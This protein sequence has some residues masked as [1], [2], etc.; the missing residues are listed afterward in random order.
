VFAGSR[1][2][3]F[4][5]AMIACLPRLSGTGCAA[6]TTLEGM[7][8]DTA[9]L[10]SW[11]AKTTTFTIGSANKNQPSEAV[12]LFDLTALPKDMAL[13]SCALRLV[14]AKDDISPGKDNGLLLQLSDQAGAATPRA[15]VNLATQWKANSAVTLRSSS[16]CKTIEDALN[17]GHAALYLHTSSRALNVEFVAASDDLSSVPRLLLTYKLRRNLLV[18]AD[19]TQIRQ[20]AQHSAR[21]PG[22]LYDPGGKFSTGSFTTRSFDATT[23][24][25]YGDLKQAP[26]LHDGKIF[27]VLDGEN[28]N[29]RLIAIN[30][31]GAVLAE[32]N[33][34]PEK[35]VFLLA[36]R[37]RLYYVTENAFISYNIGPGPLLGEKTRKDF[38]SIVFGKKTL[39]TLRASPT[40][41]TDGSLYMVTNQAVH[42]FSPYPGLTELWRYTTNRNNIASVTL[43]SDEATAYVLFASEGDQ[44][45]RLDALATGTGECRWSQSFPTVTKGNDGMPV[46]VVAG[47]DVLVTSEYPAGKNLYVISDPELPPRPT[48]GN[49]APIAQQCPKT[50]N[51]LL[52]LSAQGEQIAAPMAGA[53]EKA[54]FVRGGQLCWL[55]E[56]SNETCR[57]LDFDPKR[58]CSPNDTKNIT[59]LVGDSTA[60]AGQATHFYGLVSAAESSATQV[61]AISMV[62]KDPPA[63]PADKDLS[64]QSTTIVGLGPNLTLGVDGTL[65]NNNNN[66]T[67]M[68]ILPTTSDNLQLSADLLKDPLE[69]IFRANEIRVQDNL[70][71]PND[72]NIVL[73]ASGRIL[74][75]RGFAVPAGAQLRAGTGFQPKPP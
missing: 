44:T 46:P 12:L 60:V 15:A 40:I 25:L 50:E 52:T 22:K 53:G 2:L 74:F 17:K 31:V 66:K 38:A 35:P 14:I 45:P 63:E 43:S 59:V 65:Y 4:A 21:S 71:L 62:N 7:T 57:K 49:I 20:D 3:I 68:A 29:Y 54:Y 33:N 36:G 39:E 18:G 69:R 51:R 5:F 41:G 26:I 67:L 23:G 73:Q 24:K 9:V 11:D 10:A 64:C 6:T 16:L 47:R 75:G 61:L 56:G 58:G 42:A 72:A 34:L 70:T 13:T 32:D 8:R 1:P 37:G 55:R 48:F 28:G 27:T 19:W 30:D